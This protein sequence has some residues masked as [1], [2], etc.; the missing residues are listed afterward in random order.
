[1]SQLWDFFLLEPTPKGQS[2][3][4]KAN[5]CSVVLP[6]FKGCS[7]PSSS[8]GL[9]PIRASPR[10]QIHSRL[11][12]GVPIQGGPY[13]VKLLEEFGAGCS[14]LAVVFLEAIAVS[15]FYG[16]E[17]RG[18]VAPWWGGAEGKRPSVRLSLPPS[19]ASLMQLGRVTVS[20]W[21]SFREFPLISENLP[22]PF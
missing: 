18:F 16:E 22:A 13:I 9:Q 14:I 19:E 5:P 6:T 2:G 1:M 21:V 10:L 12:P 20:L 11:F 3:T 15:W 7:Q 8:G 4:L 17:E